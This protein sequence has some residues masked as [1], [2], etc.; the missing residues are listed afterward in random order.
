MRHS[1][2]AVVGPSVALA[3]AAL[4]SGCVS[5]GGAGYK[6]SVQLLVESAGS[7]MRYDIESRNG[8]IEINA[9]SHAKFGANSSAAIVID[10]EINA[11][12]QER[13]DTAQI[14]AVRDA[15]GVLVVRTAWPNGQALGSEGT[16]FVLNVQ[17]CDGAVVRSSNGSVHIAGSTGSLN[18]DTSNGAI[19]VEDHHGDVVAD[20]SNGKVRLIGVTGEVRADTSNGNMEM[21][22]TPDNPGPVHAS[23]S[24]GSITLSVG[25]GFAGTLKCDTSNGK[26]TQNC[27]TARVVRWSSTGKNSG[28]LIVGS[29]EQVSSVK[30]SNG[31]I[32]VNVEDR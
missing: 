6:R 20:T 31:S 18:L 16:R 15:Q 12:T 28:S 25:P 32:H 26:L 14:T 21:V 7:P 29:P 27:N 23:S 11:K 9:G 8:S 22:L 19:R 1:R 4:M 13:A 2:R 17:H 30:T 10:A 3:C 5:I 24:N